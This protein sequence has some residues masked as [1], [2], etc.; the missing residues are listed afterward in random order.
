MNAVSRF[1]LTLAALLLALLLV[2]QPTLAQ[3]SSQASR[4]EA[5]QNDSPV[6][7]VRY[8]ETLSQIAEAYQVD[9]AALMALNGILDPDAIVVGQAL[10]LPPLPEP[11]PEAE[12]SSESLAASSPAAAAP[13]AVPVN[14]AGKP[15]HATLNRTYRVLPGDTWA[16]IALRFGVELNALKALNGV[17]EDETP[18]VTVGQELLLPATAEEVRVVR[19]SRTYVVQPGDSLGLIAEA[20]GV[21][22]DALQ[23]VNYLPSPDDIFIGQELV[24]P[25]Q[26]VEAKSPRIGPPRR[27]FRYHLVRPGETLSGLALQY[28]TTP[29]AIVRYND[30]PDEATVFQGLEVRI[31]YGPPPLPERRPPVPLSGTRFLISISRQRC[32]IFQGDQV[33][34]EWKCS[35]GQGEW[36]TRTGTFPIKTKMEMAQSSAYRL[37]MPYWLGLYDVGN[38][39]NGIHGIPI[40]WENGQKLWDELVGQPATFGCAMLLDQDAAIL[41]DMAYLGMPVHIV[42]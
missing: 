17:P 5:G 19:P 6:H 41:Y 26:T 22:L 34:H 3:E 15:L 13:G 24:I 18:R 37:D 14:A 2:G 30:L 27:G 23:A 31:P 39:E 4:Q 40:M 9:M 16:W 12:S 21:T 1:A 32:W 42:D 35:T 8:G 10:R 36:V 28:N 38:F 7:V 20:Q 11:A 33:V 25:G 29:G